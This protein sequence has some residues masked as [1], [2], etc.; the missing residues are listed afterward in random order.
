MFMD[1]PPTPKSAFAEALTNLAATSP[2]EGY[3]QFDQPGITHAFLIDP[4][5]SAVNTALG[6]TQMVN[7]VARGVVV[8]PSGTAPA[9]MVAPVPSVVE[10]IRLP[11]VL[12][13]LGY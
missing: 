9:A 3:F 8:D 13:I 1:V 5:S 12:R 11:R 4:T 10:Q 6:Q 2:V 7:F